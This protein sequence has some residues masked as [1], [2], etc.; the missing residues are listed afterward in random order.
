MSLHHVTE[1]AWTNLLTAWSYPFPLGMLLLSSLL[2]VLAAISM[3]VRAYREQ[4]QRNAAAEL[5]SDLD[6]AA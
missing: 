6:Q 2:L 4:R 3:S 5:A 1:V